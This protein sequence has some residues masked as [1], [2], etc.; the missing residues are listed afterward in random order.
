[1]IKEKEAIIFERIG[2]VGGAVKRKG[3]VQI[4]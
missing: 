3:K 2:D 4:T 1:M